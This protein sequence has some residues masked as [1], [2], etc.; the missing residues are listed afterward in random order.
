[1]GDDAG[2]EGA[3]VEPGVEPSIS[4]CSPGGVGGMAW[5]AVAEADGLLN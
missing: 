1:M 2:G 4:E 3:G 5:A